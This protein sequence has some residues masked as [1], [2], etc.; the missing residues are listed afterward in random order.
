MATQTYVD[1]VTLSAATE[2]NKWD[3][4]AYSVL[5][6]VAGTNTITATGPANYSYSSATPP[7]W[8][9]AAG[10]NTAATTVN[11]SPSGGSAL[12][13]KNVFFNGV[14]CAGG[15]IISGGAY[16]LLYDGTQY[17]L[18]CVGVGARLTNTLS[19]DVA[20]NNT[21]TFFDGPTNAQGTAGTWLCVGLINVTDTAGAATVLV[22]LWDGTTVISAGVATVPS[23]NT[24]VPITLTGLITAPAGN[25]RISAKDQTSTSGQI[26]FSATGTSKDCTLTVIRIA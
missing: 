11:V 4:V 17:Q 23:I 3:T 24:A 22:K 19:G 5:T 2:W 6:G 10:T 15:E 21:G 26:K 16:G 25:I 20:L 8:F 9:V 7:I 14:A 12:G 1:G 18:V 13:A